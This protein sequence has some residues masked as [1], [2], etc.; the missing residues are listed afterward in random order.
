MKITAKFLAIYIFIGSL[1]PGSDYGQLLHVKDLLQHVQVHKLEGTQLG[2]AFSWNH[3]IYDHFI[4]PDH[5]QH[6][7]ETDH[8]EMPFHT[9]HDTIVVWVSSLSQPEETSSAVIIFQPQ[10]F[11]NPFHLTGFHRTLIEP[12]SER[13]AS[14]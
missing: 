10:Y 14:I 6:S 2:Q 7:K 11:H 5:H 9:I 3:F 1:L 4:N 8:S 12:P 13:L